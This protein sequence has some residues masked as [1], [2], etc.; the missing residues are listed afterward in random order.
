MVS[1]AYFCNKKLSPILFRTRSLLNYLWHGKSRYHV[2]SDFV[3][4]YIN[5]VLRSS[6]HETIWMQIEALRAG[7][8]RNTA[9]IQALDLGAKK[10]ESLR[11]VSSKV[12][13][14]AIPPLYGKLLSRTS[15]YFGAANILELG[16][17][18]GISALYLASGPSVNRFIT[19]EG[20]PEL[21]AIA[22]GMINKLGLTNSEVIVGDFNKTLVEALRKIGKV[23]LV[24]IDGDHRK[25][26][27][28]SYYESILPYA[29]ND[30]ILVFDDINWSAEMQEAWQNI[31]ARPEVSLSLD[32]YRM[33]MVFFRKEI[34]QPQHLQ[35]YYW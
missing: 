30:T 15:N 10:D 24:F 31:I 22:N 26:S 4:Q 16:T 20:N 11:T 8:K 33:G 9:P 34:R 23:D 14:T 18:T 12:R 27:T 35:L 32:F 25:Q 29:H 2:H 17:G 6:K 19:L 3:F 5:K 7:L 13:A 28:I 21:A 1:E